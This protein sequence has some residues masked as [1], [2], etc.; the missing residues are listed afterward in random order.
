MYISKT[1][2]S[3]LRQVQFLIHVYRSHYEKVYEANT[4]RVYSITESTQKFQRNVR[5]EGF[6]LKFALI[7]Q[8]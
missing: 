5:M 1:T 2:Q 8:R 4:H 6:T 7:T 3:F